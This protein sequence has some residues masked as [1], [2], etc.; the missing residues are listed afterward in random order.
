MMSMW[1]QRAAQQRVAGATPVSDDEGDDADDDSNNN[2][3]SD[4]GNT[5][6]SAGGTV[7]ADAVIS[8]DSEA[9]DVPVGG[10]GYLP[11]T[12]PRIKLVA[13]DAVTVS[14]WTD[15]RKPQRYE[16]QYAELT[17]DEAAGA[18]GGA[19]NEDRW[20]S[21][22]STVRYMQA[23]VGNLLPGRPYRFRV[24]LRKGGVWSA[25]SPMSPVAMLPSTAAPETTPAPEC[26]ASSTTSVNVKWKASAGATAGTVQYSVM[27]AEL[28]SAA[29]RDRA[30]AVMVADATDSVVIYS[31]HDTGCTA[32]SLKPHTLYSFRVV[33]SNPADGG[34]E[35]S[36]P[37]MCATATPD[38]G[39]PLREI[40]GGWT[41]WW[42][43]GTER[44]Y[45]ISTATG[46][47]AWELPAYLNRLMR[48]FGEWAEYWDVASQHIFYY[49]TVTQERSWEPPTS[50]SVGAGDVLADD[51]TGDAA[52]VHAAGAAVSMSGVA[53]AT[54]VT[55]A[56]AAPFAGHMSGAGVVV[57][58]TSTGALSAA[59]IEFRRKR[60]ALLF[61][62]RD[63][64]VE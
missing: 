45:Y 49:N 40:E 36:P 62:A 33:A 26:M 51:G 55:S 28:G 59:D 44:Y 23:T 64:S 3:N 14:W 1:R 25:Y 34:S 52:G 37:T 41:E 17:D 11:P 16:V 43:A 2:S 35:T 61:A 42:D 22:T 8:S 29:D 24:R 21:A 46:E 53:N 31:G 5:G 20:R 30:M 7:E 57:A 63:V 58:T 12:A 27:C 38:T 32:V 4:Q 39:K 47:S 6:S 13:A 56:N 60:F 19:F 54:L 48:R 9:E 50:F 18:R 15:V 10:G